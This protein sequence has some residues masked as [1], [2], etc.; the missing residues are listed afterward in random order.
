MW[1]DLS[2]NIWMYGN[3]ILGSPDVWMFDVKTNAWI[4]VHGPTYP[5]YATSTSS[6]KNMRI[7]HLAIA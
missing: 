1:T 6:G 3:A 5:V 4:F 2:D 7:M